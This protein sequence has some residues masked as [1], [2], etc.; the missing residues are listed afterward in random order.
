MS[1]KHLGICKANPFLALH[2]FL[3][4][5][6]LFF[7][8]LTRFKF[9]DLKVNVKT[10]KCLNLFKYPADAIHGKAETEKVTV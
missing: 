3:F 8:L 9:P 6:F 2:C 7:F 1:G 10:G 5:T 4:M